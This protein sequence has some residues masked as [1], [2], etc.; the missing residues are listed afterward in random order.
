MNT[1]QLFI[2]SREE[3]VAALAQ[4]IG[5][6]KKLASLMYPALPVDQAHRML[7]AKLDEGR[8]EVLSADDWDRICVVGREH[9]CHVAKWWQDDRCGYQRTN[10]TEPI[11]HDEQLVE[12]IE[13]AAEIFSKAMDVYNRRQAAKALKSVG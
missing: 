2:E 12:R 13:R 5:G 11:D 8:R 3:A 9:D 1:E 6:K 7:L 4:R 10:P